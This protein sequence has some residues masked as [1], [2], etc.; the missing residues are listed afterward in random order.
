MTNTRAPRDEGSALVL[1]LVFVLGTGLVITALL[2]Q[3]STS[4]RTTQVVRTNADKVY[5]ADAGLEQ[6]IEMLRLDPTLCAEFDAQQD[7]PPMSPIINGHVVTATCR[8]TEGDASGSPW[9]MVLTDTNGS[10]ETLLPFPGSKVV[11]GP[12]FAA[13]LGHPSLSITIRNGSVFE[14]QSTSGCTGPNS[15]PANLTVEP[16]P[17][18]AYRCTTTTMSSIVDSIGDD[19]P[20]S[21]PP[22]APAVDVTS[23]PGCRVFSPGTYDVDNPPVFGGNQYLRTG[24]YYFNN[25]TLDITGTIIGG[26]PPP[27]EG[28]DVGFPTDCEEAI[29]ADT[30][31]GTGVKFIFG[32]NSRF[33]GVTK[34]ELFARQGGVVSEDGEMGMSLHA[35]ATAG[36]GF[37]A[38]TIPLGTDLLHMSE[39]NGPDIVLHGLVFAPNAAFHLS[40]V[41]QPAVIDGGLV[42]RAVTLRSSNAAG[43]QDTFVSTFNSSGT[44][45]MVVAAK[46]IGTGGAVNVEATA[47]IELDN[48]APRTFRVVSWRIE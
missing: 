39:D 47:V 21:V 28:P 18:F 40:S 23:F 4:F 10:L 14:H 32:G 3:T 7:L 27:G 24:T 19:L 42:A 48:E 8:N 16:Q 34:M 1:A 15:K 12:V 13:N 26:E 29:S 33:D 36:N 9:A 2:T 22:D 45:E 25:V 44:R 20:S 43:A 30:G 35:P 46:A 37:A 17:P 6:A 11:S 31:L 5:A 38:S 41:H